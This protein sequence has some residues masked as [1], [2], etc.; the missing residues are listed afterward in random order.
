MLNHKKIQLCN[1]DAEESRDQEVYNPAYKFDLPY[2][3]LFANTN[4]ISEKTDDN[5][6][7]NESSWPHSGYVETGSVICRI[8]SQNKNFS[9]GGF[10]VLCIDYGILRIFVY[11]HFHNIWNHKKQGWS[12]SGPVELCILQFDFLVMICGSISSNKKLFHENPTR[13]VENYF[14]TEAALD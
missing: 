1:K 12:A 5:Q 9:K 13:I 7:I 3:V 4:A 8:L 6:V 2:K 14:V 10:T 11:M